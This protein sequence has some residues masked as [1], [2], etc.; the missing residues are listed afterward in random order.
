MNLRITIFQSE[1]ANKLF[2]VCPQYEIFFFFIEYKK[3]PKHL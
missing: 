1:M 3:N 2:D